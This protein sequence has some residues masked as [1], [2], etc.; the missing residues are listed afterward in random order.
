MLR[1]ILRKIQRDV[2]PT[3]KEVQH[4]KGL[5]DVK[6]NCQNKNVSRRTRKIKSKKSS[7]ML[8]KEQM[9]GN[10]RN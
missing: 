1:N 4:E 10:G 8:N 7:K 3:N 5:R 6:C 9:V 2:Y